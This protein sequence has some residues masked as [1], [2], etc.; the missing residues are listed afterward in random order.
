LTLT[1]SNETRYNYLYSADE[2]N[3]L[4][5]KIKA[6]SGQTEYVFTM[7]NNHWQGY[8][9]LNAVYTMKAL[10]M[11]TRPLGEDTLRKPDE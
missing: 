2:I 6:V 10:Q 9:P 3:E 5:G 1:T 7:F 11:R 4:V 8:A